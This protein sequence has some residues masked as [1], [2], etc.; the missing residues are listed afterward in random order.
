MKKGKLGIFTSNV[1]NGAIN[2]IND[3]Y[4]PAYLLNDGS[5]AIFLNGLLQERGAAMAGGDYTVTLSGG[6]V[7]AIIFNDVLQTYDKLNIYGI[8]NTTS[9]VYVND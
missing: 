1:D 7:S 2:G 6:K 8:T 3:T 9:D 5:E 4:V